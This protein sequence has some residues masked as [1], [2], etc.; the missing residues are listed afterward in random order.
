MPF[1]NILQ[2]VVR[3]FHVVLRSHIQL[4]V[5]W[6]DPPPTVRLLTSKS[7]KSPTKTK[8]KGCAFLEFS[9]RNALQQ[10]LK[11]HHSQLD[12]R[13]I[14]VEL[15]AGGGGKSEARLTKLK[16]RNKGLTAQRVVRHFLL[17]Y[18]FVL[19]T[20]RPCGYR[21]NNRSKRT[22]VQSP[23][24]HYPIDIPAPQVW[25]RY[26]SQRVRGRWATIRQDAV[27]RNMIKIARSVDYPES[28]WAPGSMRYLSGDLVGVVRV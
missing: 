8:S 12:E 28:P 10:G 16:E 1:S 6:K 23:S 4:F 5:F 19:E 22:R 11:L 17:H 7:A 25:R 2:Y 3:H 9:H 14:N 20:D 15:T 24:S 21:K 18:I 27:V 13:K 26:M